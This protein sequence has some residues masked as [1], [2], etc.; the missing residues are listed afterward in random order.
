MKHYERM[1]LVLVLLAVTI[2]VVWALLA[3]TEAKAEEDGYVICAPGDYVNIRG[4][5]GRR[6]PVIGRYETGDRI[7]LDGKRKNGYLHCVGL[8]L[9]ES[10][11]WI[12]AG[13]VVRDKPEWLDV[14]AEII[15]KGRLAARKNVDGRRMRWLKRGATV[16][17]YWW[18][19]AWCVTNCGYVRSEYLALDGV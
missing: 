16:H 15:S 13:Y 19:E 5:P 9:E 3:V 2:L 1:F 7:T 18:S 4:G 12:H 6:S 11:G 17:V 14:G 10:E 8:A